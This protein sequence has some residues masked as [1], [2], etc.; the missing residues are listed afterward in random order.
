MDPCLNS[1]FSNRSA[2]HHLAD[3]NLQNR[4]A[5]LKIILGGTRRV[6]NVFDSKPSLEPCNT[7]E[8]PMKWSEWGAW[9]ECSATCGSGS[10]Y[11]RRECVP[12]ENATMDIKGND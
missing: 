7:F 12:N 8:C 5:D 11:K 10:R 2:S 6:Q 4:I 9:A 1:T 3:I